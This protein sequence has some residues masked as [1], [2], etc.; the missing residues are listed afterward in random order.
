MKTLYIIP[1]TG[2]NTGF[3]LVDIESYQII[4]S[5]FCSNEHFAKNDLL[6]K[7]TERKKALENHYHTEV[8][9]KFFNEQS[10]INENIFLTQQKTMR[11]KIKHL[12]Y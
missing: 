5:H 7:R 9:C 10:E 4:A 2:R 12:I 3:Y 8:Q 6:N 1:S 11:R